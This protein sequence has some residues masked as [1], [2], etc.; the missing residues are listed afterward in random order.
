VYDDRIKAVEE[1][2][3]EKEEFAHR[4][5]LYPPTFL[6]LVLPLALLPFY[7]SLIVWSSATLAGYLFIIRRLAPHNLTVW[8][9]LAFPASFQ[10]FIRGQ[11][12]FISTMLLGGGLLLLDRYPFA[13]GFL[14]GLIS[15]KPQLAILVPIALL[16]G[17][18]WKALTAA[19]CSAAGMATASLL[20]FGPD[21]WLCFFRK[22]MTLV[23]CIL[24]FTPF[25]FLYDYTILSIPLFLLMIDGY[26]NGM[27]GYKKILW[28]LCWLFPL[29]PSIT[30][31]MKIQ[32]GPFLLLILLIITIYGY[33]TELL[34]SA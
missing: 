8:L 13:G 34:Q 11:N 22:M 14:L 9:A 23:I 1:Q 31:V 19:I 20:A 17:R 27:S 21:S 29:F 2:V 24:L 25:A 6:L 16:A 26:N 7:P 15:Y 32:I 33:I 5:W 18:H 3:L 12:A 30:Y 28:V 4:P 10:N